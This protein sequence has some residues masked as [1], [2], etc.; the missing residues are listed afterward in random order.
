M[1]H[2]SPVEIFKTDLL[3]LNYLPLQSGDPL[4][5]TT[6]PYR[7]VAVFPPRLVWPVSQLSVRVVPCTTGTV[8][9]GTVT[10]L[11]HVWSISEQSASEIRTLLECKILLIFVEIKFSESFSHYFY[12][13]R[14]RP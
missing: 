12:F 2:S 8:S 4:V 1:D 5:G 9:A 10:M 11:L 3:V 6:C 13:S 14:E 7:H